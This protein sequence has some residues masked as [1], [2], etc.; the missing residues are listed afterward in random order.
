MSRLTK[1]EYQRFERLAIKELNRVLGE[2]VDG[3][4]GPDWSFAYGDGG[5]VT[6]HLILSRSYEFTRDRSSP[7]LACRYDNPA[8]IKDGYTRPR[9][10]INWPSSAFTYPSGKA[11]LHISK[12]DNFALELARHLA[13]ITG[14]DTPERQGFGDIQF[15]VDQAA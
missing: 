5:T 2:P 3:I 14:P 12:G 11:N 13:C 10:E 8:H 9:A 4:G 7:W 6:I 15:D 1:A